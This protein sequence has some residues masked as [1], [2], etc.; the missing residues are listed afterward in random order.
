MLGSGGV[1][2]SK[3]TSRQLLGLIRAKAGVM[4]KKDLVKVCV[5][6][7]GGSGCNGGASKPKLLGQL[8]GLC[9]TIGSSGCGA[10][11]VGGGGGPGTG[12]G[13]GGTPI[14][15]ILASMSDAQIAE[16]QRQCRTVLR[17]PN[18]YE[19]DLVKLCRLLK[20]L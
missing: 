11:V 10:R 12:G 19:S 4:T 15:P 1:I 16:R 9:L 5:G 7:G 3:T 8:L 14:H 13:N 2:T 18:A 6:V 17:Q 20:S